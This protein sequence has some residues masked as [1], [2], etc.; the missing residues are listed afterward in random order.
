MSAGL[1]LL[2]NPEIFL[3]DGLVSWSLGGHLTGCFDFSHVATCK[4]VPLF[5]NHG[6][7]VFVEVVSSYD[8]H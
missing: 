5:C 6:N 4:N 8:I 3:V 7:Y 1:I 2:L